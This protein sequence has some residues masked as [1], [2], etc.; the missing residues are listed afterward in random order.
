[1]AV[2]TDVVLRLSATESRANDLG[3][4]RLVHDLSA[5]GADALGRLLIADGVLDAQ[6]DTVFSDTVTLSG[7]TESFDLVGGLTSVLTGASL[8]YAELVY[9]FLVYRSTNDAG[10]TLTLGG[11]ANNVIDAQQALSPGGS[12]FWYSPEG[13]S[14]T[15][16][17]ADILLVTGTSGDV[18]DI[19]IGGRSS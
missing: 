8:N 18:F 5:S 12:S 7:A 9:V 1:M 19:V 6:A 3:T 2:I 4:S 13:V 10:N 15:A 11:G 17:T 14:T 16:G